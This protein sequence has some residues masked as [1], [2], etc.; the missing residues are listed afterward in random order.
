[1]NELSPSKESP[2]SYGPSF[3]VDVRNTR[4][5]RATPAR[6]Q[7]ALN[8]KVARRKRGRK[9]EKETW[10]IGQLLH[11]GLGPSKITKEAARKR[12]LEATK[13]GKLKV[14]QPIADIE[15]RLREDYRKR[16]G[17]EQSLRGEHK[18]PAMDVTWPATF[19]TTDYACKG[20]SERSWYEDYEVEKRESVRRRQ[21]E[22]KVGWSRLAQITVS[23]A[24]PYQA[25]KVNGSIMPLEG[26]WKL[27]TADIMDDSYDPRTLTFRLDG[28][29]LWGAF[30]INQFS[31][32]LLVDPLPSEASNTPLPCFWRG[33]D[34]REG[35][36]Q[37][38][39]S[40]CTGEIAFLGGG[41]IMGCL[42]LSA[43]LEFTG[44]LVAKIEEPARTTKNM[45]K[46]WRGY[47]EKAHAREEV[48]RWGGRWQEYE[49]E[50]DED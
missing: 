9:D 24:S 45:E 41:K 34:T 49:D 19:L 2:F 10:Y 29:K 50:E 44:S 32:I 16:L 31:G 25:T 26:T 43:D 20:V 18:E 39:E 38:L 47:N 48:T 37:W 22:Y 17:A 21:E 5:R 33:R 6:I 8:G 13:E 12:L 36:M 1:M 40:E 46:E 7:A 14:P 30:E 28:Q 23:N 42:N 11:Y 4:E 27:D 15:K 35:E 3:W